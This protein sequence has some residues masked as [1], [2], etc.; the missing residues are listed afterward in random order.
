MAANNNGS[1]CRRLLNEALMILQPI[2]RSSGS[3]DPDDA[4]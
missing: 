4:D 3:L 2:A 1:E